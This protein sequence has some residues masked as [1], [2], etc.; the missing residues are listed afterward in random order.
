MLLSGFNVHL[1]MDVVLARNRDS[2]A[3]ALA[4]I[5]VFVCS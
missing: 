2:L 3:I 4:S 5:T 1:P